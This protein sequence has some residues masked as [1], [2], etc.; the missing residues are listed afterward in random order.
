MSLSVLPA[1][2]RAAMMPEKILANSALALLQPQPCRLN[3]MLCG[4][5][6]QEKAL[7]PVQQAHLSVLSAHHFNSGNS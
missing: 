5:P 2:R 1:A 6:Q 7:K 3:S 4:N